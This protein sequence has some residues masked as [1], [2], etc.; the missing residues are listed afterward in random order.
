MKTVERIVFIIMIV[1]FL[2]DAGISFFQGF[3]DGLMDIE[4]NVTP[5]VL[6]HNIWSISTLLYLIIKGIRYKFK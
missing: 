3:N 5:N 6:L 4:R 1:G 2:G